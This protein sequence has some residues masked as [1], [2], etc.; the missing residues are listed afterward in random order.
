MKIASAVAL[1]LLLINAPA[2][3]KKSDYQEM[4]VK[5]GGA[6]TGS[7]AYKG[8]LPA[9]IMENLKKGKNSDFCAKHPDTGENAIRPRHRVTAS[10]GKLRDAVVYIEE[11]EQG[12][13][14]S[15]EPTHFDFRDCDIFPKVSVVRK[16][17]KGLKE[18]L[19]QIENHDENILHN[20]HGYSVNGANRKTLFNKPLPSKGDVADVTKSFKRMKQAK[21]DHFF[22]QCDQ[23]NY[24]EADARVVWNPYFVVTGEDGSY[25][26]DN[27][28]AGKYKVV[29]W[30]PYAGE[31]IQEV[32]VSADASAQANFELAKK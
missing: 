5:N 27:I 20:P 17:P 11:I 29:A 7:V 28:P 13:A 19:V 22:L 12:K 30:H 24:M 25:K 6:I 21:D 15:A 14:W 16:T 2:Y 23:H 8:D 18:G 9:P 32:T 10:D 26:I 4:E 1:S 31:T 3:A